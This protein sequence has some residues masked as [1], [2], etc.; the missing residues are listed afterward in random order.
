M[1]RVSGTGTGRLVLTAGKFRNN[2]TNFYNFK[3]NRVNGSGEWRENVA[4][5]SETVLKT[6]GLTWIR[7][8]CFC[9]GKGVN[10]IQVEKPVVNVHSHIST[11]SWAE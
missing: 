3:G 4:I 2:G 9:Q 11:T 5:A 7:S 1:L 6:S 10:L 8:F